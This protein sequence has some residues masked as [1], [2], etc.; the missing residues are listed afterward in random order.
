LGDTKSPF[1]ECW[2]GGVPCGTPFRAGM[3]PNE[4][5]FKLLSGDEVK[6]ATFA[7]G[8]ASKRVQ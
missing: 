8:E 7:E 6:R 2:V 4:E 3:G 1:F 5:F